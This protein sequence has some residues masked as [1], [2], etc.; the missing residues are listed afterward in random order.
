VT[1]ILQITD[2]HLF[3]APGGR[4][5]GVDVDASLAAVLADMRRRHPD[6]GAI[7]LTGDLVHEETAAS[8]ARLAEALAEA[9]AP[10]YCLPGNHEDKALLAE[11]CGRGPLRCD[12]QVFL[13][14]WQLLLLDSARPPEPGGWLAPA[15]LE[16]VEAGLA[17][18]PDTPA[19]IALHHPPLAVNSPWLDPMAVANG[20]ELLDLVNR[21]PQVRAVVFGHI[22]QRHETSRGGVRLLG[23]PSTCA[24]FRPGV[25]VST[26]D[27][28]PPGYRWLDL[29]PDGRL[30]TG[31]VRVPPPEAASPGPDSTGGPGSG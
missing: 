18:H 30:A 14:G 27:D 1:K 22:H 28:R 25:A 21:H 16:R 5:K 17:A 20:G 6:A 8:Y 10:V 3:A 24:Q 31:V 4:L 9:G 15:E 26:P 23:T 11:A 7:L 12:R 2:T 13:G 19:L 29:A